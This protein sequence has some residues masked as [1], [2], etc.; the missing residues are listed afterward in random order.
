MSIVPG[1]L[2]FVNTSTHYFQNGQPTEA[3]VTSHRIDRV[4]FAASGTFV[5]LWWPHELSR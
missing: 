2:I 3:G 4:K 1:V 5:M